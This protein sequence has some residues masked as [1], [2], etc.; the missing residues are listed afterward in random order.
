MN[1]R[2]ATVLAVILL[3]A[4]SVRAGE[5]RIFLNGLYNVSSIK[6]SDSRTFKEFTEQGTL[7][8][9]YEAKAAFG[10]KAAFSTA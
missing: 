6:Y 10:F 3:P 1:T 4:A 7:D 2:L 9:T 8:T 5:A